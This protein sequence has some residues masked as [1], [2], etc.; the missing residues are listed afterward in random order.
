VTQT[1]TR[2]LKDARDDGDRGLRCFNDA[3]TDAVGDFRRQMEEG[4]YRPTPNQLAEARPAIDRF[5]QGDQIRYVVPMHEHEDPAKPGYKRV[6]GPLLDYMI[7]TCGIPAEHIVLVNHFSGPAPV[8]VARSY[9]VTLV[10]A[11]QV[12]A[13]LSPDLLDVVHLDEVKMGKGVA[14]LCGLLVAKAMNCNGLGGKLDWI[15]WSDSE[16]AGVEKYD[17]LRYLAYPVLA[18]PGK[19]N[20]VLQ[21]HTD[22]NNWSSMGLRVALEGAI[23]AKMV[24]PEARRW[25]ERMWPGLVR[26][27]HFHAGERMVA[28]RDMFRLPLG[29][30][31]TLETTQGFGIEG[32]NA[33][34]AETAAAQ[35]VNPNERVDGMNAI[36][37]ATGNTIKEAFVEQRMF[38]MSTRMALFLALQGKP[39][40]QWTLADLEDGNRRIADMGQLLPLFPTAH[41]P[42]E[43]C[44]KPADRI[45][46]SVDML[47]AEGL[48]EMDRI[49][50][51]L[52][53]H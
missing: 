32:I 50:E 12:L 5:L 35:V 51:M 31:Y 52:A 48:V 16:L 34:Y 28:S 8:Q 23:Y 30:G 36:R 38:H 17:F 9:G 45:L 21:T 3:D 13:C 46:P 4:L 25:I 49:M 19:H 10:D 18:A 39:L 47:V 11:E 20:H 41:G 53:R 15:G 33:G 1:D 26:M 14:M 24:Q 42:M 27:V 22:R 43:A 29:T 7:G 2:A 44:A 40:H 37:D 6:P